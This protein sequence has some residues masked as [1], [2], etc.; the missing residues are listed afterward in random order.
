M[1]TL[2]ISDNLLENPLWR[3]GDLGKPIPH[4]PHA[5]SVCLPTWDHVVGYEEKTPEVRDAMEL[6]Y[7][8]FLVHHYVQELFDDCT[9]RF[10][11]FGQRA[12]A[13]PSKR[14]AERCRDFVLAQT[15]V[16]GTL[17]ALGFE[18]IHV[19][20][21]PEAVVDTAQSFW[22]HTGDIIS[23]RMADAYL[24]NEGAF[25]AANRMKKAIRTRIA[26]LVGGD[27]EDVFLF[28]TGMAA[29]A[30]IHRVLGKARPNAKSVQLGFPYV[31]LMKIQEKFGA[32]YHFFPE[33]DAANSDA[34]RA[35]VQDETISGV[36]TD[37]PGNPLLGCAS[38]PELS[39]LLRTL[40]VPLVVDETV[41][42]YYNV[43]AL[44]HADIVMTSL[45]KYFSGV[46]NVMAGAL[47]LNN[48]SPFYNTFRTLLR[49][50][51]E[52]LLWGE[53]AIVLAEHSFNFESRMARINETGEEIADYLRVHPKVKDVYYPKFNNRA[54][55]SAVM[56]DQ[57]GYGGLMSVLVK[58]AAT[59]TKP[60][61]D[62]LRVCKGPSLG[63]NYTLACPYTQLAHFDELDEVEAL[64]VSPYLIRVSIGL[65]DFEDLRTRF[66]E[67]LSEI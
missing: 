4:S 13:F 31:D 56:R 62:N 28:A 60:F 50:D 8:R 39:R 14:V 18:N 21:V 10:A 19:I 7:P 55:Y 22:Q 43:D 53:D 6:G 42:T 65:E 48:A 38:I 47:I 54:N 63:T 41:G 34:F 58:D 36:F 25:P 33:N 3:A 37:L 26:E 66:D 49:D 64:G 40:D 27:V 20:V 16:E 17:H 35:C 45:T 11:K 30:T 44:P 1:K 2:H 24:N 67:A 57:G 46:S 52:D 59:N 51:Y 12:L 29:L 32:G 23:S 15:G 9:E 5:V 61:Y